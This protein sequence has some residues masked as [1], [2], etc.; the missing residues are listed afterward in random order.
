MHVPHPKQ[1][2]RSQ[3]PGNLDFIICNQNQK[4]LFWLLSAWCRK[5]NN[6][7]SL[8]WSDNRLYFPLLKLSC[9]LFP[10]WE[11][12]APLN[13]ILNRLMQ[14]NRFI[15]D[16][17][18]V[19]SVSHISLVIPQQMKWFVANYSKLNKLKQWASFL[20]SQVH[21]PSI[22]AHFVFVRPGAKIECFPLAKC[23]VDS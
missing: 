17:Q 4:R 5:T 13:F 7:K 1:L 18:T 16:R 20:M 14:I 12:R 23:P 11:N 22:P 15:H 3:R 9:L 10:K 19:P 2:M 8:I 6:G 21:R